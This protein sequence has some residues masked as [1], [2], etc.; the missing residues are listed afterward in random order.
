[1]EDFNRRFAR[2]P[3][4]S[5]DAHRPVGD[6]DLDQ[7]FSWHEERTMGTTTIFWNPRAGCCVI[8]AKW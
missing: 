8:G 6:Q 2:V 3:G 5:H 1:M 4:N 7:I